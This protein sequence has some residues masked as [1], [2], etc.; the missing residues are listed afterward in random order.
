M[1]DKAQKEYQSIRNKGDVNGDGAV[2]SADVTALYDYILNGDSTSIVNGDQD[3]DGYI[4][5][6]DV[7][8][9]YN[10]MLGNQ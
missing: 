9:V 10:I 3:G 7:T 8:T 1:L 4:T 5:S 2:N 6:G